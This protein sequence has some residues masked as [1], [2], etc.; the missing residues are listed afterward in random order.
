[1]NLFRCFDGRLVTPTKKILHLVD[2]LRQAGSHIFLFAVTRG[3]S[4]ELGVH[5][6]LSPRAASHV[7]TTHSIRH[8][9][10]P[11]R[12]AALTSHR[13][14][15]TRLPE[16]RRRRA[17][18]ESARRY[19]HRLH[20]HRSAE[21]MPDCVVAHR[22]QRTRHEQRRTC[23]PSL[24]WCAS[25]RAPIATR[26]CE[27][28]HDRARRLANL[29][30]YAHTTRARAV[31]GKVAGNTLTT[32]SAHSNTFQTRVGCSSE[33]TP[34]ARLG[35]MFGYS[36]RQKRPSITALNAHAPPE[37]REAH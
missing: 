18:R 6:S 8:D 37:K 11:R 3:D 5:D 33:P 20:Q 36:A 35:V 1:V 27:R 19:R 30:P 24:A 25:E 10:K 15:S 7:V 9:T 2:A 17:S 31:A 34:L 16:E 29:C 4:T 21:I 13:E 32:D 23:S 12:W 28:Q 14:D 26:A 22:E